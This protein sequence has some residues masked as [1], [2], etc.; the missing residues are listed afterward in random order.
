MTGFARDGACRRG[1][2]DVGRHLLCAAVTREFLDFS[3]ARE[4]DLITP[5]PEYGFPGLQPGDHW[6][7]C[8]D[9]WLEALQAGVA[10]PVILDATHEAVL[11]TVDLEI[12][13]RYA[14][15]TAEGGTP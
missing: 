12:L 7:L 2:R 15:E 3:R 8:V 5:V 4:N 13:Q 14:C 11:Q 9:R 10:P 1:A 6:C